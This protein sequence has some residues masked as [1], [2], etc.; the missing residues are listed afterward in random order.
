MTKRRE[1]SFD[2]DAALGDPGFTPRASDV[3][4]LLD[5]IAS[6]ADGADSA[7]RALVRLGVEGV[8]MTMDRAPSETPPRRARLVEAVARA[9]ASIQDDL[10]VRFLCDHLTDAEPR[11]RRFA[12]IGLGKIRPSS[13]DV[14]SV[15]I[16][17]ELGAALAIEIDP[18][19]RRALVAAL[20]RIG[21]EGALE[22]LDRVSTSG[23]EREHEKA[24]LVAGR[25][26]AR[27]LPSAFDPSA[28]IEPTTSVVLRCRAGLEAILARELEDEPGLV[29]PKDAWGPRVEGKVKGGLASLLRARTWH[30]FGFA[31]PAEAAKDGLEEALVRALTSRGAIDLL[32]SHTR[33]P[34]RYRIAWAGG[35]KRRAVIWNAAARI[36]RACP[37]LVNDP[38]E[39]AWEAVVYEDRAARDH[40]ARALGAKRDPA[41]PPIEDAGRVRVE[42]VPRFE[43]PRFAYRRGD[44]PA[45][46][47]PT[48]AAALVRIAGVRPDDV[49]WDPFTGSGTELCERGLAGPYRELI[50]SDRD[51]NALEVAKANLEAALSGDLNRVR[52]A[53]GD[54]LTF[55]P[56]AP[57]LIITNPPMGRRVLRGADL[58]A[59]LERFVVRAA[60]LLTRG[61]RLVW[62][63]PLPDR[64]AR[65]AERARLVATLRRDLDMGG[66]TAEIQAFSKP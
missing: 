36:A 18:S 51:A 6:A 40:R 44:V 58:G 26:I 45:A 28:P 16:A 39:S 10:V 33:G 25:S 13:N 65:A 7:R 48:I 1:Q 57:T 24:L 61:G 55:A 42:L 32:K 37:D 43:D 52:L 19:V 12:A 8:R 53:Q 60:S 9:A 62:I 46:S 20:G 47:H 17:R 34:V 23:Q 5:R 27:E 41:R 2:L 66:F 30:S 22:E 35:G 54:A 29:A 50:G 3:P 49:V 15:A 64:T 38:T 11:A 14:E 59:T 21:G 63:S 4:A 31:L 56:T